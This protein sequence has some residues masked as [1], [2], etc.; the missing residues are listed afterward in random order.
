MP[1]NQYTWVDPYLDSF[2]DS[3]AAAHYK[4]ETIKN[5]RQL[6][7]KL[8]RLMDLE[9]IKPSALTPDIAEQLG[10]MVPESP[11]RPSVHTISPGGSPHI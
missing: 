6:V 7:R 2:A 5:Y 9:R 8:G 11:A 10:R 1:D 4:A 3:C